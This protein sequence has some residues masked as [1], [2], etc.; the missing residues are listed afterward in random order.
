[1]NLKNSLNQDNK[2]EKQITIKN[3]LSK[4]NSKYILIQIFENIC[5]KSLLKI[6]KYNKEIQKRIEISTKDYEVY[7]QIE[8]EVKLDEEGGSFINPWNINRSYLHIYF[9]DSTEKF[10]K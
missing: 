8:I 10:P 9:N 4:I 5:T 3:L 1:M 7:C 2:P 6:V